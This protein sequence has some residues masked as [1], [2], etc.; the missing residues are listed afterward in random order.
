MALLG[1]AAAGVPATPCLAQ[2]CCTPEGSFP[3]GFWEPQGPCCRCPGRE[4]RPVGKMSFKLR[5]ASRDGR[6]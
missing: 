6:K 5:V 2:G 4:Y 3:V 1:W